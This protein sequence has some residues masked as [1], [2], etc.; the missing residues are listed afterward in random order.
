MSSHLNEQLPTLVADYLTSSPNAMTMV[1]ARDLGVREAD[2][3]EFCRQRLSGWQ[4]PK[5]VF[6]LLEMPVSERGKISR[7]ALAERFAS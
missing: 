2:V 5:R 4:V 6:F 7:R 3:L 1:I